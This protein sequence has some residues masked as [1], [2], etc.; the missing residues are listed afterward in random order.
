MGSMTNDLE[1]KFLD[2]CLNKDVYSKP[3]TVYVGLCTADPTD[4][5]TGASCN[6]VANQYAYART[7][8]TFA[9][10]ASRAIAQT[11]AVNFPQASGGG[12]GTV[13]HWVL[14][15]ASAYGTGNV[16]AYGAFSASKT[17]NDGNTASIA[18]GEITVSF[19]AGE[20]S[21]YLANIWLD[22]AFR[23][24][25]FA[26]PDTYVALVKTT[27]VADDDTGSSIIEPSGGSYARVQ[28]YD[29]LSGSPDWDVAVSGDPSY[30]DN[31]DDIS[32]P[33]ATADWGTIIAVAICDA[34][35]A[36]NLLFY[37]N[38]MSDQDVNNGDTAKFPAGDLGIQC[39]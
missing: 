35:S 11:S 2:H 9:A 4:A 10:A 27:T 23:N 17:I 26:C 33:A 8:I 20:V 38:E 1:V 36:G 21:N 37:D 13:S 16:M 34:S 25:T 24:Q 18:N 30:V 31:N 32:F 15:D 5:A 29:N 3:A 12:W 39:S 6:E 19:S 28:V 22:Y 7:A 14:L